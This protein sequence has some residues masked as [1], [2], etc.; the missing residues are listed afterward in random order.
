MNEETSKYFLPYQVEWLNDD[1]RIKIWEKSRRIGATYIQ[2]Y[3][4]VRDCVTG[5][6]PAVWFSSADESAAKEYILY[7]EKWCK[8]LDAAARFLGEVVIDKD[9]DIKALAIQLANGTR[10]NALT[11][12]PKA[13]RS[14]GGKIVLDEFAHHEDQKAM[15]KAAKPSATWGYPIRILSTHNG[16]KCLFF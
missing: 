6:V 4:D 12:N 15:W 1:S 8:M 11:S 9:K 14:K 2:S 5:K 10:I 3:E 16:K 7:C 13:F